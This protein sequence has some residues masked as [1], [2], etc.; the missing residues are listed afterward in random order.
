MSATQEQAKKLKINVTNIKSVLTRKRKVLQNKRRIKARIIDVNLKQ[1]KQKLRASGAGGGAGGGGTGIPQLDIIG[2][3]LKFISG[4]FKFIGFLLVGVLVNNLPAVVNVVKGVWKTI[5]PTVSLV[6]KVMRVVGRTMAAFGKFVASLFNIGK[7]NESVKGI[8]ENNAELQEVSSEVE[9]MLGPLDEEDLSMGE[10]EDDSEESTPEGGDEE[11][12]DKPAEVKPATTSTT[13][14][15]AEKTN[16]AGTGDKLVKDKPLPKEDTKAKKDQ[17]KQEEK[18]KEQWTMVDVNEKGF[19]M[20]NAAGKTKTVIPKGKVQERVWK[21]K[22]SQKNNRRQTFIIKGEEVSSEEASKY[23]TKALTSLIET[24]ALKFIDKKGVDVTPVLKKTDIKSLGTEQQLE[25][26]PTIIIMPMKET[27]VKK[28]P[29]GG[30]SGGDISSSS[31]PVKTNS[32]LKK[33]V[34]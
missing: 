14:P 31:T 13:P 22:L 2:M 11:A 17:K 5:K 15:S 27:K 10:E 28:V 4:V 20:K 3:G 16:E 6:W 12:T 7:A 26:E 25:G 24:G 23:T 9:E 30:G 8:S 18:P 33:S 1:Q 29:V 32:T 19:V 21:R 34:I